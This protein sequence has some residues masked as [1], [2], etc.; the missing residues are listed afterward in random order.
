[1]L[2]VLANTSQHWCSDCRRVEDALKNQGVGW[3]QLNT[4]ELYLTKT[5]AE[6]QYSQLSDVFGL[7]DPREPR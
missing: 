2:L 1:M 3:K 4:V 5:R 6:A 7:T